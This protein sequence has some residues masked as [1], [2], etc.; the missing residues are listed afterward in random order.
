MLTFQHFK[1]EKPNP[2]IQQNAGT[3]S[4]EDAQQRAAYKFFCTIFSQQVKK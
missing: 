3:Q 4:S 1:K 2:F